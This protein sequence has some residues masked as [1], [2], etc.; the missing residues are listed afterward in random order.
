VFIEK[1]IQS[2]LLLIFIVPMNIYS[3]AMITKT[4]AV[5]IVNVG[6]NMRATL[7]RILKTEV[8]GKCIVEGFV[9]PNS[10]NIL[11]Y[12]SG[13]VRGGTVMFEAVYECE[14]CSPVEGMTVK[15]IARNNTKAGVRAETME[16]PS[17]MVIFLSRDHHYGVESFSKIQSDDLITA[18]VIGQ[19]FEIN[20]TQVSVIAELVIEDEDA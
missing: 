2:V 5:N 8:E 11:Q 17:P 3:P 12:S 20:D 4:I 10:V 9:K 1:L 16:T 7:E 14:V 13:D 6:K 15:C 18:R 19:R